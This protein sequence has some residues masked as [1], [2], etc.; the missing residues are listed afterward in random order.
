MASSTAVRDAESVRPKRTSVCLACCVCDSFRLL[1]RS[2]V[3][4]V[5]IVEIPHAWALQPVGEH[6]EEVRDQ[7]IPFKLL[8]QIRGDEGAAW[9][10]I[11]KKVEVCLN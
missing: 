11:E 2:G 8:V 9:K 10:L 7:V 5:R 3:G 4:G 1:F 6:G